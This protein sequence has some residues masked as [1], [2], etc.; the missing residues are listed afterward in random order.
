MHTRGS[1]TS[2]ESIQRAARGIALALALKAGAAGAATLTVNSSTDNTT[3][4]VNLTLREA[5]LLVNNAGDATAALGRTLNTGEAAQITGAFGTGDVIQFDASLSGGTVYL[6]SGQMAIASNVTITGPGSD[7]LTVDAHN[8]SRIF[9]IDGTGSLVVA[10]S[11][12]TLYDGNAGFYGSGGAI[13]SVENLTLSDVDLIGNSTSGSGGAIYNGG[14]L[15]IDDCVISGNSASGS[16]GG[17][18]F[19]N[20][21][22]YLVV[23]NSVLSGNS[24]GSGGAVNASNHAMLHFSNCEV[25]DNIVSSY[26]ST[27]SLFGVA[28]SVLSDCDILNNSGGAVRASNYSPLTINNSTISGHTLSS[29]GTVRASSNSPLIISN[30]TISGNTTNSGGS[31]STSSNSPL[32]ISN[33][34]ISGNSS[35]SNGGGVYA[36]LNSPLTISDSVIADNYSASNVGGVGAVLNSPLTISGSIISDNYARSNSGGVNAAL[37]SPVSISNSVVSGNTSRSNNGGVSASLNSPLT[38]SNST[39]SGNTARSGGGVYVVIDS[40]LN[41]SGS[42]ISGNVVMYSSAGIGA[43]ID[44]P[45]TISESTISGNA[46]GRQGGGVSSTLSSPVDISDSTI[47]ENFAGRGGGGVL[48]ESVTLRNTTIYGNLTADRGGGVL[49]QSG[50]ASLSNCTIDDNLARTGGGV[51]AS[52]G[53]TVDLSNTIVSGSKAGGDTAGSGAVNTYYYNLVEDGSLYGANMINA[54]PLLG[55]LQNNGGSTLTQRPAFPSSPAIDA[56]D[57]GEATDQ[58]GAARPQGVRFD[59]GAVEAELFDPNDLD[60]DGIPNDLDDDDDGDGVKD[61][62]DP[63]RDGDGVNDDLDP[64]PDDPLV[65]GPGGMVG[66]PG[67]SV[68]KVVVKLDFDDAGRD[69]IIVAG[70]FPIPAAFLLAGTVVNADVGGQTQTFT[71]DEKGKGFSGDDLFKLKIGKKP[72]ADGTFNAKWKLILKKGTF[73]VDDVDGALL[74]GSTPGIEDRVLKMTLNISGGQ[75]FLRYNVGAVVYKS[76]DIKGTAKS[77]R[78]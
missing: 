51:Y 52:F 73:I 44:S 10:I 37:Y 58:R 71:L 75:P 67:L 4:D 38:I 76:T 14:S 25:R 8:A 62:K 47:S 19:S 24:S 59:L 16:S 43:A 6:T 7:Q 45:V 46:A 34:T 20:S 60:G 41:I 61:T 29:G 40:P 3:D 74:D 12:M 39:I 26:N 23:T 68:K 65:V 35:N 9:N 30:S 48:G 78:Q 2:I 15:D 54:D 64:A 77:K 18:I 50:T 63:D 21:P 53:T 17:A 55:P 22:S 32:T 28:D 49:V 42:T 72:N 33:S 27:I 31:V 1:W 36:G 70:V 11:G 66:V 5:I 13:R 56:S 57:F 69:K